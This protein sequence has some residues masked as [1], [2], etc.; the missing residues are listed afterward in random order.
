MAHAQLL[1]MPPSVLVTLAG[2]EKLATRT[3]TSARMEPTN[4]PLLLSVTTSTADMN[5]LVQVVTLVM[6]SPAVPDVAILM[7]AH[8]DHT[9]AVLSLFA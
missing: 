3:L 5:A 9:T 1:T 2:L 7:N 4:V 8:K 6:D